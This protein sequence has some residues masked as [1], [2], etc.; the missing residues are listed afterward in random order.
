MQDLKADSEGSIDLPIGYL[1]QN[2]AGKH[3]LLGRSI[4]ILASEEA[5]EE[6]TILGC[7]T[8]GIDKTP[9]FYHR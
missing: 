6:T 2:L 8:I 1:E 9:S 3:S 4:T 5:D 7:C